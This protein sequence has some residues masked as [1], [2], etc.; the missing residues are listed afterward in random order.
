MKLILLNIVLVCLGCTALAQKDWVEGELMVALEPEISMHEFLQITK[1]SQP[2][3]ELKWKEALVPSSNIHL[4]SFN[5]SNLDA[6]GAINYLREFNFVRYA[7]KNHTDIEQRKSPNDPNVVGQWYLDKINA[8]S[9]WE[10]ST[11]GLTAD[12]QEIVIAIVDVSFEITHDDLKANFWKNMHEI[13]NNNIDDDKNGYIDD[14]DGWNVY[15]DTGYISARNPVGQLDKHG[16][17]VAGIIGGIGN[18]RRDIAGLNWNVKMLP[19]QGSST[20]EAVVIKSYNYILEMRKRYNRTQGDSGVFIVAQNSSFGVDKRFPADYPVWCDLIDQLG[21]AGVVSIAAGPNNLTDIDAQGDIP[22]TCPSDYLVTVT[23]SDENDELFNGG[24]GKINMDM[25][26][27]GKG[28]FTTTPVN[29]TGSGDGASF[30]APMAAAAVGLMYS[31]YPT[32][33]YNSSV[34][35]M[36]LRSAIYLRQSVEELPQFAENMSTGGRL[37]LLKAVTRAE[38]A[39][40]LSLRE[41]NNS[42]IGDVLYP[43]PNNGSF[44]FESNTEGVLNVYHVNGTLI[45]SSNLV[46]GANRIEPDAPSKGLY[47]IEV[48]NESDW[49]RTKMIIK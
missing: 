13:P 43:N 12:S 23:R 19:V 24:F 27:P 44:I 21:K 41:T 33:F 26:A 32:R 40:A 11:G 2:T 15:Q 49:K 31:V 9:A 36:A 30:A 16:T 37:D 22:C 1:K 48:K 45:S 18:N 5:E 10:V 39:P 3:I 28:I 4:L 20:N 17:M 6:E 25:A 35:S 7:Q 47:V 8:P 38:V 46:K 42:S 14:F 29:S 34:D